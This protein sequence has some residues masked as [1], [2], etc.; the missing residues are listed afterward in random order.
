MGC[1][2]LKDAI[3]WREV[4]LPL[5]SALVRLH[6]ESCLLQI[7]NSHLGTLQGADRPRAPCPPQPIT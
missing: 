3:R 5:S 7:F 1:V 6:L 4:V 2:K